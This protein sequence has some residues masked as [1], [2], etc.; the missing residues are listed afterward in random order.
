L[1]KAFEKA[2][3]EIY[4]QNRELRKNMGTTLVASIVEY[5]GRCVI[6]N[7][8]DSRAYLFNDGIWHT[9]DHKLVQELLDAGII[10]G[11]DAFNNPQKHI[12]TRALGIERK[13]EPDFYNVNIKNKTLLLCSDGLYD[14]VTNEKIE[15]IIKMYEHD[16]EKACKML[17]RAALKS[18]SSDNITVVIV[19]L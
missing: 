14:Y 6:A 19:K 5:D 10:S 4:F 12:L 3:E 11:D 17:V 2:N 8:G 15:N 1:E 16:L 18:G 9:R 7:V 13:V